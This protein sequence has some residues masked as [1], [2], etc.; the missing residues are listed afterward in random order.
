MAADRRRDGGQ[1]LRLL[2]V[3][4]LAALPWGQGAGYTAAV[5]REFGSRLARFHLHY[6]R[7]MRAYYGCP[8][9]ASEVEQCRPYEG[10]MNA[11][12]FE[13]ARRA[14]KELFEQ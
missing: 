4:A 14:A 5:P 9:G 13:Q 6:N 2:I 11:R 3:L 7:F 12:E 10:T 8:S 1:V